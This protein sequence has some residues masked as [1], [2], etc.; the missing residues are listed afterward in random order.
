[1]EEK[2][3]EQL[4]QQAQKTINALSFDE[5]LSG[6]I[7]DLVRNKKYEN[8]SP[9]PEEL[10]KVLKMIMKNFI[11]YGI[12]SLS[13][14]YKT[15][16]VFLLESFGVHVRQRLNRM[17]VMYEFSYFLAQRKSQYEKIL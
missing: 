2:D 8:V 16:M 13:T 4:F 5:E 3:I 7:W 11:P 15:D 1:M 17:E 9:S 12:A 14:L 10:E 6:F